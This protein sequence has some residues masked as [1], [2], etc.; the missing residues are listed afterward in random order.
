[1]VAD[2]EGPACTRKPEGHENEI[3]LGGFC[4]PCGDGLGFR[5]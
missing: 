4:M 5:V 3:C 2:S 1:M